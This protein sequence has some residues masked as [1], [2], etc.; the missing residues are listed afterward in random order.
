MKLSNSGEA[1]KHRGDS[2]GIYFLQE[3]KINNKPY[4]IHQSHGK[5]IWWDNNG[6][7]VV[8]NF[9]NLGSS[10]ASIIGPSNNNSPPNQ[11]TNGWQYGPQDPNEPWTDTNDIH[12]EDWTFKQ[13]KFLHSLR[14]NSFHRVHA[15]F[16][17]M[18]HFNEL[19]ISQKDNIF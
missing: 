17:Q 5:A 1:Q 10:T 3:D 8:G 16:K 4:W 6:F 19:I 12:F 18:S 11:I 2:G 14:K 13:G 9:G 7:W 15:D